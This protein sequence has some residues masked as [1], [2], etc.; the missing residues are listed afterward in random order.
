VVAGLVYCY[1]PRFDGVHAHPADI[2]EYLR[3]SFNYFLLSNY[4]SQGY[5]L[6]KPPLISTW[7]FL[8][9]LSMS[10]LGGAGALPSLVNDLPTEV[11]ILP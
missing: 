3:D 8:Q 2:G 10:R 1:C 4:A 9:V 11:I 5:L 6:P 7:W